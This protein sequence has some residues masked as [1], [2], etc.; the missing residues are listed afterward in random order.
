[1]EIRTL[2]KKDYKKAI[3][4]AIKG[5]HFDW[6]MKSKTLL[7]L[8]GRYFLYLEM[9]RA[10]QIIAAYEG[11]ELLGLLLAE[12]YHEKPIR[13]S[14]FQKVYVK[15]FDWLQHTFAGSEVGCYDEANQ[16]M[17]H[18]LLKKEKPD[19]E[20]IF[21]SADPN[22]NRKGIG[23]VLLNE[24]I[25]REKGKVIYLF[26]DNACTYQFYERR[27]FER[28]AERNIEL[29]LAKTIHLECYLYRRTL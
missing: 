20:L 23:T 3:R 21:L 19:G 2:D 26:T 9:N 5:M 24:L 7:K 27:G 14:V 13:T 22:V 8:Y 17:H 12:M 25:K 6:Y 16:F 10:T 1:M 28:F 29:R 18:E 4:F 15:V 11:E